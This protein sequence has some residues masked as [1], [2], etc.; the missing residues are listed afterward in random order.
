MVP[1]PAADSIS[2]ERASDREFGSQLWRVRKV[3]L[4]NRQPYW[5]VM[6]RLRAKN[7][8]GTYILKEA[9]FYLRYNKVVFTDNL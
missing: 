3:Y 9:G 7:G 8:F 6:L 5:Y 2:L 1:L 4:A